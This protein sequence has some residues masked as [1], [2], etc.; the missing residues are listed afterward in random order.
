MSNY[1]TAALAALAIVATSSVALAGEAAETR[2]LWGGP[3]IPVQQAGKS[4]AAAQAA[5]AASGTTVATVY[6]GT[7]PAGGESPPRR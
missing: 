6:T 2:G 3:G 7:A 5:T 1:T 4:I